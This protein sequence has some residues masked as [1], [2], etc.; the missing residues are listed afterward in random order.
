MKNVL[1]SK[2]ERAIEKALLRGDFKPI[3]RGESEKIA[4]AIA[5]REKDA[6][7]TI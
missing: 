6:V 7:R 4:R 1:L 3:G 5:R 2:Q